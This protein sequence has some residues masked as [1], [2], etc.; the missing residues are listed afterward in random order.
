MK[1]YDACEVETL[2]MVTVVRLSFPRHLGTKR[3][4]R[5]S[6]RELRVASLKKRELSYVLILVANKFILL[7]KQVGAT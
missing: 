4:V 1:G 2:L 5:A 6:S 3:L 7:L